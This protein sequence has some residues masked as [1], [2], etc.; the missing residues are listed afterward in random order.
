M[1]TRGA[2]LP[3]AL[4][5]VFA[6]G[7][8]ALELTETSCFTCHVDED[9]FDA[10]IVE[11][12]RAF[13]TGVHAEVGILCH[14][15]HGGDPDPALA[16]DAEAAMSPDAAISYIGAPDRVAIPDFCGRCHSDPLFMRRYDP[17]A[18]VDQE[19]EY[20]TSQHGMALSE[21]DVNVAT[22]ID[23]HGVHGIRRPT[24]PRSP[25]YPTQVAET[26][27]SC[28]AD[29]LRMS[30]YTNAYGQARSVDQYAR[31][32]RSV[33]AAAL[34]EREDLS[35]PTCNDCHGNHG[36][37][38][39][40]VESVSFVC[41]QCHG[42]EASLFRASTKHDGFLEHNTYLEGTSG[43]AECHTP[44]SKPT[45]RA[46]FTECT[47]CHGNHAVIRPTVA[48]LGPLPDTPCAFCHELHDAEAIE[49]PDAIRE[50]YARERDRLLAEAASL[51]LD[52]NERFDWLVDAARRLEPHTIV[53][54]ASA[55][56]SPTPRAEFGRLYEKFRIGKTHYTYE[57]P[58]TGEEVRAA[59]TRC[60]HCHV[61][62]PELAESGVGL[63][64]AEMFLGR[65]HQLTGMTARAE[66]ILLSAQRGGVEL[67][68]ALDELD[69]AVDAQIELEVL[70]HTF[71]SAEEG[72]FATRQREGI[73]HAR[74][75]L[76]AGQAGITE[77]DQRRRGLLVSLAVILVV[78][79]GLG[80]KISQLARATES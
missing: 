40:G 8:D 50:S 60:T 25:V 35:A 20:W 48:L 23:C 65:M 13:A 26:C 64:T 63:A 51:E 52:G 68:G 3:L 42:R 24:D 32:R 43:C 70:V 28:H 21:G 37:T 1:R 59:V 7:A 44:E 67:H 16:E 11:S 55:G 73:E 39:P 31:W 79:I 72:A 2:I 74:A 36:A 57:D 46:H 19:T 45:E 15:C 54:R 4:V 66:R 17:D 9:F 80:A 75:A 58:V 53:G 49:E 71:S 14:D 76:L 61:A 6:N 78:L 41:G 29:P 10:A 47:S 18:R 69:Q 33:H 62:E 22:C 38:P 34:L 56:A 12:M 30:G 27:K 77:L 5:A